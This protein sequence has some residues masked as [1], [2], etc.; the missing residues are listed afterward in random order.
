MSLGHGLRV[1]ADWVLL[2]VV[3]ALLFLRAM[4]YRPVQVVQESMVPTLRPGD[5]LL[6]NTWQVKKRLPP[7]GAIVVM[8]S[9]EEGIWLVKR[10]VAVGGDKV[11]T[12]RYGLWLNGRWVR[13]PY[14]VPY[15]AETTPVVKVPKDCVYVLGDNRP[16]SND[17]RDFGPVVHDEVIGE[18]VA[19]ISPSERRRW[20]PLRAVP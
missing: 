8:M 9:H 18:A 17:S 20:L 4:V 1:L 13:E 6:V 7:R 2:A 16:E 3:L 11:A 15:G 10:V 19:V 12:G 5:R 14:A